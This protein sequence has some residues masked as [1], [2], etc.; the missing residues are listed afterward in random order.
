MCDLKSNSE[1]KN[2]KTILWRSQKLINFKKKLIQS[3]LFL[4]RF[5][6]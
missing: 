1:F 3:N 6:L 4:Y 2:F 5:A